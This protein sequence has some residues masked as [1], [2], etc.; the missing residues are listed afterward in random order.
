MGT[1]TIGQPV[2]GVSVDPLRERV[3]G[4]VLTADD[5]GYD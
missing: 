3:R 4:R 1:A 5:E 2:T